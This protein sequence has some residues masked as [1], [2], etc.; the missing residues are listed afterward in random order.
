MIYYPE[1]I[2]LQEAYRYLGYKQ[3]SFPVAE[4]LARQ[5]L[6]LP[7]HTEM[8]EEQLLYIT[9]RINNFFKKK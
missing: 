7:M 2:H 5:V 8:D 4:Q 1:V 9:D 6:S 3:G